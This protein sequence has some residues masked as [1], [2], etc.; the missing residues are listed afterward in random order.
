[1][2]VTL[3]GIVILVRLEQLKN[4][5]LLMLV[6]PDEIVA[7]SF[8]GGQQINSV[9][10]LLSK[11]LTYLPTEEELKRELRIDDFNKIEE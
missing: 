6:T 11:Y 1:M 8:P 2:F 7:C 9:F 10:S 5:R 4:A 3:F